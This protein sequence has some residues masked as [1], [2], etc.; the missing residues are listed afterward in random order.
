MNRLM[1][2]LTLLSLCLVGCTSD[3]QSPVADNSQTDSGWSKGAMVS[4]GNPYA[5]EAG[6]EMLEAG[7]S[8]IDA[9]IATHLVL[10]LVEPQSSGLGGGA[11][12][13]HFE[14][15]SGDMAFY[16]GRETAPA[17][18]TVDMFM[19]DDGVLGF[20][21]SV[22]SGHAVG[23]PGVVRLYE[24]AHAKHGRLPWA[25]L[26]EPAYR[27]ASEGFIVSPRLANFLP[28]MAARTRLAINPGVKDYFYPNGKALE[29]GQLLKNPEYAETLR[30]L[31]E[32]GA[33]AF[34][35]GDIAEAIVA[36]TTMPPRP[37]TLTLE[38]L[39]NYSAVE[40]P[41]IC[42]PFRSMTICSA[43]PPSSG[44]AQIMMANLYDHL[45]P[46]QA[47]QSDQIQAFV[48]AQRLAYADRDH[49]FADPDEVDIPLDALLNPDYLEAR[50]K[51]R[52]APSAIPTHGDP[53]PHAID[54]SSVARFGPDTTHEVAGTTHLSVI[55]GDGNAVAMTATVESAFG[56]QRWAKGFVLNNEMTDFARAVPASGERPAN[57]VAPNRRPR[58]SMSPTMVLSDSGDLKLV[59]GSPGGNSI[60][61]YVGKTVLGILDWGLSAQ[62]AVD[63]PNI[64]ARG[65]KV[66]VEV[67]IDGG[68]ALADDLIAKGY[69]V[70]EREGENSG[71]HVI[72]VTEDGLDGAADKRREGVVLSLP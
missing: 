31:A 25:Q 35:S 13:L 3:E 34:Y 40:R 23:A 71:L 62:E 66:R 29:A 67:G 41:V 2:L 55:D 24:L 38:D 44:A 64:I 11:F 8:A 59:T 18:A 49:Y 4:A 60:P 21:D 1:P 68:Q 54:P 20:L 14:R 26:F 22:Q 16:D 39:A 10:G 15:T 65:E 53:S 61:A 42:G 30:R 12:I 19:G 70:Q 9:A 69:N 72:H 43:T 51:E 46:D 45:L 50:A 33:D 37:G 58:S 36:A 28:R 17:G 56:S 5:S 7:G 6:L 48:D 47:D 32:E 57:A 52:F 63:R 27:L